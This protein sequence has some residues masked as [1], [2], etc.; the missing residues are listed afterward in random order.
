MNYRHKYVYLSAENITD[1]VA[2][3]AV[4][5]RVRK[6]AKSDFL[7]AVMCL[8]LRPHGKKKLGFHWTE[9]EIG[10]FFENLSRKCNF[11]F[12]F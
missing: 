8:C 12:N 7:S 10:V 9:F 5:R 3:M 4:F 11:F 2:K 6:I 1:M